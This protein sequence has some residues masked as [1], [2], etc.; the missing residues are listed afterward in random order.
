[1]LKRRPFTPDEV[2]KVVVRLGTRSASVVNNR[3]IPDICL[4]HMV[5][6]MLIDRT[7]SFDAAHDVMRM[8]D[9]AVLRERAKVELVG[10]AELEARAPRREAIV[11][12]A[13]ADGTQLSEHVEAVRGTS[14]NPMPRAEVVAKCRDLIMPVLGAAKSAAL[15]ERVLALESVPNVRDLRDLLQARS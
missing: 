13:L 6:V 1:M 10:D 12:V 5:A 14:D 8:R 15:I 2:R 7:V 4:Q 11:D 9:A 3:D